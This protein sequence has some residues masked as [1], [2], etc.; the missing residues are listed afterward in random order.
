MRVR[1]W[2]TRCI[3]IGDKIINTVFTVTAVLI[4]ILGIYLTFDIFFTVW[5]ASDDYFQVYKP[6]SE[7]DSVSFGELKNINPDVVGWITVDN[8]NIDYPI[9]QGE[10]NM[11]YINQS[12]TGE[13][14]LTGAI[15]LD[16]RNSYDFSDRVSILYGHNMVADAMFGGIDLY[17]DKMYFDNHL[18]GTVFSNGK[19]YRLTVFAYAE[20]NGYDGKIYNPYVDRNSYTQWFDY[21]KTKCIHLYS[22]NMPAYENIVVMSTCSSTETDGRRLLVAKLTETNE[23]SFL[24]KKKRSP[25]SVIM[26][27][28]D[29]YRKSSY[30]IPTIMI[31]VL[32]LIILTTLYCLHNIRRR[33]K[34]RQSRDGK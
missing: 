11:V 5:E 3:V 16:S 19:Y 29:S 32:L 22:E 1:K 7:K 34:E 2:I 23:K 15:F 25:V 18:Y 20:A 6:V 8:T 33:R 14:S 13:Y 10:N 21:L 31:A 28:L 30:K 24:Q 9:V 27:K 4:V 12:V 17:S 26:R